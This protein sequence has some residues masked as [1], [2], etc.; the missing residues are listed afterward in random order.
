M[1]DRHNLT[2][3]D[4]KL[5]DDIDSHG[6]HVVKV[7]E[8]E[9]GPGF[10]YSVGLHHTFSHPEILI[11][12]LKLDLIHSMINTIGETIREGGG[13]KKGNYYSSLIEGFKCY[14]LEVNPKFYKEYVGYNLWYYRETDFPLLQCVYPTIKGIYPWEAEWPE[15]LNTLQPILGE[16]N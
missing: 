8:D 6:W 3:G 10:G 15:S 2:K 1:S 14:F 16:L 9:S 5:L 4:K 11:V 7:L 13:F 12:G